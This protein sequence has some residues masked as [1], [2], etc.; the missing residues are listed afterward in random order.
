[1]EEA[2][3]EL[4]AMRLADPTP[5]LPLSTA[6]M[7]H[8]ASCNFTTLAPTTTV[9]GVS[10]GAASNNSDNSPHLVKLEGSDVSAVPRVCL[11]AACSPTL[12]LLGVCRC[13]NV[14]MCVWGGVEGVRVAIGEGGG[15]LSGCAAQQP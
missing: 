5:T 1:M 6:R 3:N 9:L 15:T 13:H 10:G 2:L 4:M 12:Y 8:A 14:H 7:R 11:P